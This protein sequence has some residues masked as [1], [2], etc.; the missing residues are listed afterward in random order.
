MR[1]I[2]SF[3]TA[4]VTLLLATTAVGELVEVVT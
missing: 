4:I 2:K 3:S 1:F